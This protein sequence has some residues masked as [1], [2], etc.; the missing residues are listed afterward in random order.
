MPDA[1]TN[2]AA[3]RKD[4]LVGERRAYVRLA[5]DLAAVSRPRG[6]LSEI[7][8]PGQV[9]DVSQGGIG[10]V[11]RHRFEPGMRLDVEVRS[12]TGALLRTVVVRVAHATPVSA[13]GCPLWLLGC[14]FDQPLTAEEFQTLIGE[15]T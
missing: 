10:L 8:W 11:L 9:R 12:P 14:A 15:G 4:A 13:G 6:H 2:P 3:D 5:T 1:A 7:G